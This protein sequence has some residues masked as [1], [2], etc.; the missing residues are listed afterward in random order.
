MIEVLGL[1]KTYGPKIA[2]DS[3]SF[4]LGKGE[5]LGFLGPNGAGKT[6]TMRMITGFIPPT[7]GTAKISGFDILENPIEAKRKI[8]YLPESPPLYKEMVVRS[9]LQFVSEIK[10]VEKKLSKKR[11]NDA[12]ELCGLGD[13]AGRIISHL[14]KGYRQRVGLAQALLHEPEVLIFDEPTSGLDPKQIIDIRNLIKELGRERTVILSTHILPEVS[15]VCQKV[16]IIN[17][18]KLVAEDSIEGLTKSLRGSDSVIATIFRNASGFQDT[19]KRYEGIINIQNKSEFTFQIDME[20][21]SNIADT[22]A[23]KIVKDGFGLKEL[24]RVPPNL[25]EVFI[26]LI[27]EEEE[28]KEV[29]A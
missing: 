5:I 11:V 17:E 10:E 27:T 24:R 16:I 28:E 14:S 22:I 19:V 15:M 13:V 20:R 7:D 8:G 6:T 26:K 18:G 9:Y 4:N 2:V 23:E 25:E 12:I 1:K 21:S 29:Q 3:I